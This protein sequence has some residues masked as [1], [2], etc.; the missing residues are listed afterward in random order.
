MFGGRLMLLCQSFLSVQLLSV[1]EGESGE[2]GPQPKPRGASGLSKLA[3][4][5]L[6]F[7]SFYT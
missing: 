3:E 6:L 2:G 4:I 1:E 7:Y 5:T